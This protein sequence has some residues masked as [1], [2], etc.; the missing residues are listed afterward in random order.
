MPEEIVL[1]EHDCE[2]CG[3]FWSAASESS[4]CPCCGREDDLREEE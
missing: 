2:Y 3:Y 4:V 1:I